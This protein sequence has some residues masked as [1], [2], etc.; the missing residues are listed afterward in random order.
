MS[1]L[2]LVGLAVLLG[3]MSGATGGLADER[4]RSRVL[5]YFYLPQMASQ[6]KVVQIIIRNNMLYIRDNLTSASGN[7]SYLDGVGAYPEGGDPLNTRDELDQIWNDPAAPALQVLYGVIE[8]A[9][10]N[11]NAL[12]VR[13]EIYI[14]DLPAAVGIPLQTNLFRITSNTEVTEYGRIADAHAYVLVYSL[15][16]DAMRMQ[17]PDDVVFALVNASAAI[18]DGLTLN[19][20]VSAELE[21]IHGAIVAIKN[22]L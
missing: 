22:S 8:P 5:E 16:L 20:Q 13:S 9:A 12:T 11:A 15:I 7:L 17:K 14:G 10:A 3:G 6:H 21:Q 1:R 4:L 18:F 2:T 19:A